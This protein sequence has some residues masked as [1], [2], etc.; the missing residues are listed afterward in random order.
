MASSSNNENISPLAALAPLHSLV[1]LVPSS[2]PATGS[3]GSGHEDEENYILLTSL[4]P[5]AWLVHVGRPDGRWWKGAWRVSDMEKLA[6]GDMSSARIGAFAQRIARTIVQL[7]VAVAH[8]GVDFQNMKLVLGTQTKKPI[9]IALNEL[10]K[11]SAARFAFEYFARIA[12]DAR[13][14]GCRILHQDAGDTDIDNDS[15]PSK[16]RRTQSTIASSR[17]ISTSSQHSHKHRK[18][19]SIHNDDAELPSTSQTK[20]TQRAHGKSTGKRN[21]PP[22]EQASESTSAE[23]RVLK[24]ELAK[25]RADAAAAVALAAEREPTG[26]GGSVDRLRSRADVPVMTRRPGASLANPNKAARRVTA[27]EFA[28]DSD[29]A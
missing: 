26:L 24:A 28:S 15:L 1:Q 11:K 12:E 8:E 16:R 18:S 27:V 13:A 5:D 7:E 6:S 2:P 17:A 10:D 22:A 3:T 21:P 23:V 9:R 14:H 19:P 29:D 25:A 20:S 4:K